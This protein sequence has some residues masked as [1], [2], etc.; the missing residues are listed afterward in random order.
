[1]RILW[2]LVVLVVLALAV[3]AQQADWYGPLN[4]VNTWD[5]KQKGFCPKQDNCLVSRLKCINTSQWILDNYCD[6]GTWTSR[7]KLIA[8]QLLALAQSQ[9]PANYS[10]YCDS[11]DAVLNEYAYNSEYGPVTSFIRKFCVQPG[12]TK[13]EDCVNNICVMRYGNNVAFGM[14]INTD[15]SGT[16]SPLQA[17]DLSRTDCD[18]VKNTDGDYDSCG[19]N[20][21]Y[22]HDTQSILYSTIT[23]MPAITQATTNAL[24]EPYN[25]LKDYVFNYVHNPDVSQYNY[26]FF[27]TTPL[28]NQL[29]LAKEAADLL[30]SFKQTNITTTQIDYAG[31]YF[32]NINLPD[33]TCSRIIKNYDGRA[34]CEQQPS[35]TDFYIAAHKTPQTR[36]DTRKSIV[37]AWRDTTGKVRVNQ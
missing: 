29:Y 37:D 34:N 21:W 6:S 2:G 22:N 36:F 30:Y 31:W 27:N 10:I 1:M 17:L 5:Y 23:T 4:S 16:K 14:S 28:F 24:Q 19:S 11:Y 20:A 18:N 12:T 26:T 25:K 3:N 35:E 33:D 7:T 9:S 8:T 32:S 15:I 13:T